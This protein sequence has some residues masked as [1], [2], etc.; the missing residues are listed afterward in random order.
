MDELVTLAEIV[1]AQE[2]LRGVIV[3]TPLVAYP[4]PLADNN[5]LYL[6]AES[7]QRTGSFKLRGAYNKAVSLSAAQRQHGL[8][9]YSSGNHAQAVACAAHLL[10][11]PATIVMPNNAPQVKIEGTRSWGAEIIF[12]VPGNEARR[13]I[14]EQ[15]ADQQGM[16]LVPPYEDRQIIAGQ[17]TIGLEILADLPDVEAVLVPVGGG[18]LLSGVAAA[19]KL[20]RPQVA[21]YGVEPSNAADAYDSFHKGAVVKWE[22]NNTVADGL[23][24]ER[25]GDLNFA[26]IQRYVDDIFTVSEEQIVETMQH[27]TRQVHLLTE[28]SGAVATAAVRSGKTGLRGKR[29]AAVISGG[30]VE[31]GFCC[32]LR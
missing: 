14:A 31:I 6:K 30:N 5:T 12:A 2:R 16:A 26:H 19:I 7:L 25:I 1:A 29:V 17:G 9:A 13:L 11:C 24:T 18:G 28:P 23:R 10:G 4:Y 21:V 22:S 3:R 8:V 27:L 32:G 20:S 15:I